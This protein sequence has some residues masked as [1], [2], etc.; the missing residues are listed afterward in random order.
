MPLIYGVLEGSQQSYALS[1]L[2]RFTFEPLIV[3]F[4]DDE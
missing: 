3:A 4:N 2:Y 1:D